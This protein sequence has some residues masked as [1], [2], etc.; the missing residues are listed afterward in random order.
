MTFSPSTVSATLTAILIRHGL[1]VDT[2]RSSLSSS[3]YLTVDRYDE[4]ADDYTG[5]ELKVRLATHEARP[6]Y[7]RMNGAADIEIGTHSMACT[8][9][10]S[11]AAAR[12]LR[13]YAMEPDK[14]LASVLAR[15]ATKVEAARQA[16]VT[17]EAECAARDAAAAEDIARLDAILV[18]RGYVRAEIGGKKWR[19]KRAALRRQMNG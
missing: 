5:P 7:E 15:Q 6:T 4:V 8:E 10:A 2:D 19:E 18:G 12:V 3:Q 17:L 13:R 1:R 14:T 11:D 16:R 9:N